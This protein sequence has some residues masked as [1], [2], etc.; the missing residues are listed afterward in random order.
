MLA[1]VCRLTVHVSA[2]IRVTP[3]CRHSDCQEYTYIINNYIRKYTNTKVPASVRKYV[4]TYTY[5]HILHYTYIHT[6]T[7]TEFINTHIPTCTH[8]DTHTHTLRLCL[9]LCDSRITS[10]KDCGTLSPFLFRKGFFLFGV[11]RT[12]T[13]FV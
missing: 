9:E 5:V 10:T 4:Q 12:T 7:H 11:L 1:S 3:D 8:V 2:S 13:K 6:H